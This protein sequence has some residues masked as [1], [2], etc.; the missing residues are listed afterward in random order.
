[1]TDR[2]PIAE[3]AR[4]LGRS[5]STVQSWPLNKDDQGRISLSEAE[6]HSRG[7]TPRSGPQKGEESYSDAR[8]REAI[9]KADQA[10]LKAAK[11]SGALVDAAD[12]R[13]NLERGLSALKT[14]LLALP[15]SLA[16]HLID[17]PRDQVE[18]EIERAIRVVLTDLA[19]WDPASEVTEE[20]DEDD[21]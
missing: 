2:L 3:V 5:R 21:A 20:E 1:M 11:L 13:R 9:A 14:K 18:R 6:A 12:V 10:E 17:R 4:R 19:D 7:S 8:R 16:P 15:S